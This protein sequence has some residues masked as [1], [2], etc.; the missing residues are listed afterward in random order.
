MATN[1]MRIKQN[2]VICQKYWKMSKKSIYN[3]SKPYFF[4]KLS[5]SLHLSSIYCSKKMKEIQIH[6]LIG[7]LSPSIINA[8]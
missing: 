6:L 8:D 4:K 2:T 7:L 5:H 3:K 1:K